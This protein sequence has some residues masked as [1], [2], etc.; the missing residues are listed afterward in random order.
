MLE[1]LVQQGGC[2]AP[3]WS[4][5]CRKVEFLDGATESGLGVR[6]RGVNRN[7]RTTWS[8]MCTAFA[9]EPGR[10]FGYLTSGG[11]GDATAWH[12]KLEPTANGTRLRQASA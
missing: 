5:E 1:P 6:F 9:F 4:Y 11:Q 2:A 3:E 10:Q 7:G 8:R 12:F